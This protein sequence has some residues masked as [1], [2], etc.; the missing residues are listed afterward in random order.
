MT[1][2]TNDG[3]LAGLKIRHFWGFTVLGC[4][5]YWLRQSIQ[6]VDNSEKSWMFILV[7]IVHYGSK[8]ISQPKYKCCLCIVFGMLFFYNLSYISRK[9]AVFQWRWKMPQIRWSWKGQTRDYIT[10]NKEHNS[11]WYSHDN[12]FF[13]SC[14]HPWL[15]SK[16]RTCFK[17]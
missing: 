9:M 10:I 17:R 5:Q 15:K 4:L 16:K 2:C 6:S 14:R 7:K 8:F 3:V 1:V 12:L 13:I 11:L